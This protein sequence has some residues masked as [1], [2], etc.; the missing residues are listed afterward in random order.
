MRSKGTRNLIPF[1]IWELRK[2]CPKDLNGFST[3]RKELALL[4]NCLE[5]FYWT[6]LIEVPFHK[7]VANMN[8]KY[9]DSVDF[10]I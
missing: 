5:D 1:E 7:F 9:P 4:Q 10:V 3:K 6:L 2:T 8:L